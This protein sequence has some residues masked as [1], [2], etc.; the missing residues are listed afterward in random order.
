[1]AGHRMK[2][3]TTVPSSPHHPLVDLRPGDREVA[4]LEEANSMP[5]GD[6]SG[7]VRVDRSVED[8]V[9]GFGR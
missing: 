8:D 3:C 4:V 7:R 1:M 9:Q 2:R 5:V 6:C